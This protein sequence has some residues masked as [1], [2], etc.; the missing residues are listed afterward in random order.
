MVAYA[1]DVVAVAD[2]A[3][4]QSRWHASHEGWKIRSWKRFE[5]LR[6]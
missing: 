5:R 4:G 2:L 6:T 1:L 3:L